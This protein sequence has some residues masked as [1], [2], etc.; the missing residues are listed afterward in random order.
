MAEDDQRKIVGASGMLCLTCEIERR[1]IFECPR[2]HRLP[3][4]RGVGEVKRG[5]LTLEAHGLA[6][7]AN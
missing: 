5:H 7:V 6:L 3:C 4:W 1:Q 2:N